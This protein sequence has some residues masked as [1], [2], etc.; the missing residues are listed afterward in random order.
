VI[1]YDHIRSFNEYGLAKFTAIMDG[2]DTQEN[3]DPVD[4]N[5][6]TPVAGTAPLTIVDFPNRR[7]MAE[8]ICKAFGTQKPEW[9]QHE[10]GIWTWLTWVL[11][12]QLFDRDPKNGRL[13][14]GEEWVWNPAKPNQYQ[15]AQRH[16]VRLPVVLWSSLGKDADHLL[17]GRVDTPGELLAQLTSQQDMLAPS[18]QRLCRKLYFDEVAGKTKRGA[19]GAGAGSARRLARVRKQL[20]ITWDMSDIDTDAIAKLLPNEF[21]R[22]I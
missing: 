13:K 5:F 11:R 16:K 14:V 6:S 1:T 7:G 4:G 2:T 20:D 12:D 9:L 21:D 8:A 3:I 10:A 17:Y 19:A 15:K 22:F 18:F